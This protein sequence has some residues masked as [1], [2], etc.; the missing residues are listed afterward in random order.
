VK[1]KETNRLLATQ[2]LMS[3]E[4][5]GTK[6]NAGLACPFRLVYLFGA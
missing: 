3:L 1:E 6:D 4:E 2:E 5:E